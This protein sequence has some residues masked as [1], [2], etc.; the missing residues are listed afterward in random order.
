ML[1]FQYLEEQAAYESLLT[2]YPSEGVRR[3]QSASGAGAGAFILAAPL[4]GALRFSHAA[5]LT[6]MRLRLGVPHPTLM[7]MT[8]CSCDQPLPE[9]RYTHVLRCPVGG[10][11]HFIHRA[12]VGCLTHI[13]RRA[14]FS[15]V[16]EP[17]GIFPVTASQSQGR[18]PDLMFIDATAGL[19]RLI[20][21]TVA[22]PLRVGLAAG[23]A[24]RAAE[25]AKCQ[26]YRDHPPADI[27][28]GAAVEVFG[29]LGPGMDGLLRL[30]AQRIRAAGTGMGSR[31]SYAMLVSSLRQEVSVTLQRAQALVIH[32][33][34]TGVAVASSMQACPPIIPLSLADLFMATRHE[35][36]AQV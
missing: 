9:Q 20:D 8:F 18:R 10:G 31:V 3:L 1:N 33:K 6:A 32:H 14:G 28:I 15:V 27:F 11:P 29:T 17:P 34:S 13:G 36:L 30:C 5:F 22:D 24:A 4:S 35:D 25:A 12:L 19:R 2:L 26:K 23:C 21:V 7:G 16:L